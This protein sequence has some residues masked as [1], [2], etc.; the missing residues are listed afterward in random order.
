MIIPAGFSG[1]TLTSV[2]AA[3]TPR[4]T[5]SGMY[6]TTIQLEQAYDLTRLT[7]LDVVVLAQ[8]GMQVD[9]LVTELQL[10]SLSRLGFEPSAS[11][12]LGLLVE[13]NQDTSPWLQTALKDKIDQASVLVEENRLTD[14]NTAKVNDL[15]VLDLLKSFS[16]EQLAGIQALPGVDNDADGLTDTQESWW[17]TDPNNS[18]TDADG[19]SDYAEIQA[20]K[21]WMANRR[22]VAP[23]ETPWASWPFNTTTCP[24]KDYDSIP[25]LA[26]RWEL[27]LNMDL[28]STDRDKFD[29]GQEV[30]GVTYCPGGDYSCGYGDLPRSSDAGYVGQTMPSWVKAPG[31]HP[32]VTAY[33]IPHINVILSELN[34]VTVTEVTTDHTYA[35]GTEYS[36]SLAETNGTSTSLANMLT[37]NDWQESSTTEPI[38][39]SLAISQQKMLNSSNSN[40]P[41]NSDGFLPR[42]V[43][44][45]VTAATSGAGPLAPILGFFAS[46]STNWFQN[47]LTT[48]KQASTLYYDSQLDLTG[49]IFVEDLQNQINANK[50]TVDGNTGSCLNQAEG[51]KLALPSTNG[52]PNLIK[53]CNPGDCRIDSS[54]FFHSTLIEPA[55]AP[56]EQGEIVVQ[57][58]IHISYPV[59]RQS[60]T[61]T[62]TTAHSVGGAQT[63][64]TEQYQELMV[65]NGE[66]FGTEETWG[67]AT[68]VDSSYAAEIW[69]S[70]NVSNQGTDY[71]R[72]IEN[73]VFNLYLGNDPDPFYTY[74]VAPDLGGDGTFTNFMPDE[75]HVYT[76]R[77][78]PLTLE[79]MQIIDTGGPLKIIVEDFSY[80][81]DELFY[82]NAANSMVYVT[83]EDG[84]DDGDDDIDDYLIPVWDGDSVQDVIARYFPYSVDNNGGLISIWTPEYLDEAPDWC[85]AKEMPQSTSQIQWCKHRLSTA[86]W[87]N[88][89]TNGMG[90]GSTALQDSP[91]MPGGVLFIRFNQDTDMDGYSDRSEERLLTDP[92]NVEDFPQPELLAGLHSNRTG[93]Y[94]VSTLSL[95]NTGLYDAYGV[96]AIMISPDDSITITN[97]TVGGSGRVKSD[98]DVVVG[99]RILSP[100]YTE[101]S[102]TGTAEP[103]SGGYFIGTADKTYTFSVTCSNPVGCPIGSEIWSL[104]WSDGTDS[105]SLNFGSGYQSP[106]PLA[107]GSL[108]LNL[109]MMSGT[110]FNGNTFTV[111]ARTPRDTFQYTINYEPYTEPIVIVS[112]NDPQGDHRFVLPE[113]TMNLA[114]PAD[115]L[116]P[117]SGTMLDINGVEIVASSQFIPGSNITKVVVDNPTEKAILNGNIFLEFIDPEGTVVLEA[118]VSQD[119]QSG[120]NI[121]DFYWDTAGFVPA[122]DPNQD[123]IVM[124]FWTDYEGNILDVSGRPLSSFQADPTPEFAITPADETWDFGTTAKGT[125]LKREF[126]FANTGDRTLLTYVDAPAGLLVS[127]T[128]SKLIGP[129][130]IATYVISINTND[131]PV[132]AYSELI[133]I[134]TS[135][136]ANPTRTIAITGS[137]TAGEA[138]LPAL[139][140]QLPMDYA[141][142]VPGPQSVG[143]WYSFTH[144]LGPTPQ[145]IHPVKM[146]SQDYSYLWGVG[147]YATDFNSGTA[148]YE[149]F[150]NGS[151]GEL[152]ISSNTIYYPTDSSCYGTVS[153][154]TLFASNTSFAANQKVLI[155]QSRGNG[156]GNW[157]VN[158]IFSYTSG[159]IV[160]KYPLK[161]SYTDNANDQ[162]QVL[163][164]KQYQNVTI[165]TGFFLRAKP[166]DGNT[167]GIL[168]FLVSNTLQ[169]NGKIEADGN[170]LTQPGSGTSGSPTGGRGAGFMGGN[171]DAQNNDG[172]GMSQQG[173]GYLGLSAW[174][175]AANGNGG[176]GGGYT[177]P[178]GCGAG[179][180]GA[181]GS[182]GANGGNY[183]GSSLPGYGGFSYGSTDLSTMVFGGGGGGGSKEP[184]YT[185]G[186]GGS[187]AGI[188]FLSGRTIAVNGTTGSITS[189]GGNG[190]SS[191]GPGGAGAGGSILLRSDVVSLGTDRIIAIGG[192]GGAGQTSGGAGGIGRIRIDYC[193]SISGSTNPVASTQKLNCYIA[194]QVETSPYTTTRLQMPESF[195]TSK[196]YAIKYGRRLVFS[197]SGNQ[198]TILRLPAGYLK[199]AELDILIS[200]AGVGDL[201]ISMDIGNNGSTDYTWTGSVNNLIARE[202]I[203]FTDAYN[204]WWSAS[205]KQLTG[206]V[207]VPVKI[208]LSKA[209]QILLTDVKVSTYGSSLNRIQLESGSYSDVFVDI[210]ASGATN[211]LSLGIDVGDDGTIDQ[212]ITVNS[213][214]NPHYI[215]STNLASQV[216]TYLS[217]L[218]GLVN[219]PI[220]LFLYNATQAGITDF[221]ASIIG[222][223]D[224][225]L[226]TSDITLPASDPMETDVVPVSATFHNNGNLSSG[227]FTVGFFA[228]IPDV[229][230]WYIGSALLP[231][232]LP[233]QSAS[234]EILWNTSGF[235]GLTSVKVVA[236]PFGHIQEMNEENNQAVDE[237][238]VRTRPD[239]A[240]T[241]IVPSDPEP[242][243]GELIQ[244]AVVEK[245]LGE[246]DTTISTLA[247]YDGNP[248][249]GGTLIGEQSAGLIGG[250]EASFTFDWQPLTTGWHRLYVKPDIA[251]VVNEFDEENNLS[252]Q[253]IY[254]GLAGPIMLDSGTANDP[255]YS[256]ESGYGYIDIDLPDQVT[257]C[258]LG[259]LAEDTIRRDPDGTV[260][261]QFDHLLPGHFYH[262]D[263]TLF[264]CD[265]AGRQEYI[266][267][268]DNQI[269]GP[270]DLG[271]S[272]VHHLSLRLDPA[273]YVDRSV[274]I[275]IKADGI[276]GAVVSEVNLHDIDY[277]YADAGGG[278]D[279]QYPGDEAFGWID[280]DAIT[281]WGVLPYQSVRVDQIDS[282]VRYQYDNLDPEKRYN[283]HFTFWQPEGTGRVLKVQ[284]DG[285]DTGLTVNTGDYLR[286]QEKIAIPVNAYSTDG[287]VVI[288]IVRT[289]ATTG[290]MVNEIALEEETV[291]AK[292]G[293]VALETPYFSETYGSVMIENL[294]A[295][296]GSVIQAL[297]PRGDTVG[298]F[299]VTSEGSYGFMRIYGED[300]SE[301][302]IIPGMRAGEMVEY[303]V[304]GAP[305]VSSP[306]F[307]WS[308][309]HAAHNINLNAGNITGQS[310][311]LNTG[312]N[313]VSFNVEPPTPLVSTVLTSI[314][315]RYSRV[316]GEYGIYVP[317]LPN[318][319]NTLRELHTTNGY[320]IR[321]TG[322]TSVSLLVEGLA[323]DCSTP[324]QLHAGWNWIGAPCA[325]TPTAEALQSISG[326][327]QRVLSLNKTYD[328]A[329]PQYST[330]THLKPGEGYLIYITEPVTLVYPDPLFNIGD[331]NPLSDDLCQGLLATPNSTLVYGQI[332]FSGSPAPQGTVVE[333][334]TPGG[335]VAGCGR[336][337]E[338]GLLPLTQVYGKTDEGEEPGFVEG[339]PITIR[340][341]GI[342]MIEE[343]DILWTD[344]KVPHEV[345]ANFTVFSTYI[346][347]IRR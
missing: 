56:G 59:I 55:I 342:E 15:A 250:S 8:D 1:S 87:W 93:T 117:F 255:V 337:S 178:Y 303:R 293:C 43:G 73:L 85:D 160:L 77:H 254:I 69:F 44:T 6:R 323:Q 175:R 295:P 39:R 206:T 302:P 35:S 37:W 5:N 159:T 266:F 84:L 200:N 207:D 180:G 144:P 91:G 34:I 64:T 146:Y 179:G 324:K 320:Y 45:L 21:E 122:Y 208:T 281:T 143:N 259:N 201:T 204:Q 245:N 16:T 36:Y 237:I 217:G 306:L 286:H 256:Q 276:D 95:L 187:G 154:N 78:I 33:P 148:S 130:D 27:G 58:T 158:E 310:I 339:E 112:Y 40:I 227:S 167:G 38:A 308:D 127:Q 193:S 271:D 267:V 96:E 141:V 19:R 133:T 322:T 290:A 28:E 101:T 125:I 114:T 75:Q 129:A 246:T 80:G 282:E 279:P 318:E 54:G 257:T 153:T 116:V 131:L 163:V 196:T 317:T 109:A 99:S 188:I 135:D 164:L 79:Q 273:F 301:T 110:V 341:K 173:E 32:I 222:N 70:Y 150:G 298:C 184:T 292:T 172:N 264:E 270:E 194:E 97:N 275:A 104:A 132:G 152:V 49:D 14:E 47:Y 313:L 283:V 340:I 155:H 262:L 89:Y 218:T 170:T 106:T 335:E 228:S 137:I 9:L 330:L 60:P 103:V 52:N 177:H 190:A 344:D 105:G 76:S 338:D 314:Q 247:L 307:Y 25:N 136:L 108:G 253:D 209:A 296:L 72:E 224:L 326:Y 100:N 53:A 249:E 332:L 345:I 220:R 329:L 265:G 171:A 10:E 212:L 226:S 12:D 260:L 62:E 151:D 139:I 86:D 202:N 347:I 120:P 138:S 30:F 195:S 124:A 142:T 263:I 221:S 156:A 42:A 140:N 82:K 300:T 229:G 321:V 299:T 297:N 4:T 92:F 66:A 115:N 261:Y 285:V 29:D 248:D 134:H 268:D 198:T 67:S 334:L 94:V 277:R 24:D 215:T 26:E 113:S 83:I 278:D 289:N 280:G 161:N 238:Y 2:K 128:G 214:A 258:N 234:A 63:T 244:V 48:E 126:S 183:D 111:D 333:F 225:S 223:K 312:W 287:S 191:N 305:A 17:C 230:E 18:D 123:Y 102:W 233:G 304:N 325:I 235:T 182:A 199:S 239:L 176:G 71:A 311:L 319:F 291:T 240:V 118:P 219:V 169:V 57:P 13:A 22:A 181:N 327:Y 3:V 81:V 231:S 328:P 145:T 211:P 51:F 288:S 46:E 119:F 74:L 210:K 189:I 242:K 331:E 316:L 243:I 203:G 309:D 121:I 343:L 11:T 252:W 7:K 162:A 149:M 284:V 23:G 174:S 186:G 68:A 336:I 269:A 166:W 147:K 168:A 107:V 88:I 65:T 272:Q 31:N 50:C 90:D 157:E 251:D 232:V 185:S 236:D 241:G 213:P 315:G 294:N 216:N 98:K 205:S 274:T 41:T 346:P 165:G 61:R 20:I 197:A 192:I